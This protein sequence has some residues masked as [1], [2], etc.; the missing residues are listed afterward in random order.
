LD[1]IGMAIERCI[2]VPDRLMLPGWCDVF[3]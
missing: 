3:H 2:D 1:K